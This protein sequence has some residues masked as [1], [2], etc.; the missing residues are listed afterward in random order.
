LADQFNLEGALEES[1]EAIRLDPNAAALTTIRAVCCS[2][3]GATAMPSRSSKPPRVWTLIL[4]AL[5]FTRLI[6]KSRVTLKRQFQ[7]LQ[8]A[9]A[10]DPKNPDTLF[11][12]GRSCFIAINRDGAIAQWRKVIEIKPDHGEPF[13]ILPPTAQDRSAGGTTVSTAI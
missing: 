8:Q 3:C 11:V 10:L 12:L 13:T 7:M 9:A 5:V 2:T 4:G 1:R 6:E